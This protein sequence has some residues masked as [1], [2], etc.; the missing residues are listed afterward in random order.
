MISDLLLVCP[1]VLYTYAAKP[2]ALCHI[3]P[4]W[5]PCGNQ[6]HMHYSLNALFTCRL[7]TLQIWI[8][9]F[10]CRAAIKVLKPSWSWSFG[11]LIFGAQSLYL[12]LG[13]GQLSLIRVNAILSN[14]LSF[15]TA[16]SIHTSSHPC[17]TTPSSWKI[18]HMLYCQVL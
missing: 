15:V 8:A 7:W 2:G 6:E 1:L 9:P 14:F 13:K 11:A 18:R 4:A 3:V 17:Y 16:N 10:L 5:I 12:E